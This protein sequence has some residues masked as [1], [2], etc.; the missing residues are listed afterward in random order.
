M[1]DD[2]QH[3]D[4][5]HDDD[6]QDDDQRDDD[7]QDDELELIRNDPAGARKTITALRGEAMEARRRLRK[8]EGELERLKREG[9]SEQ[10][11]AVAE[12]EA[13][14]REQALAEAGTKL[15][16]AQVR[17]AAAGKLRDPDD[18]VRYLDLRELVELD[19][20][21]RELGK[22]IDKLVE[23]KPYLGADNGERPR[24]G[25]RSQGARTAP[26]GTKQTDAD[27]SAWLRKAARRR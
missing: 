15:L 22:R 24:V 12:A 19:E 5:Q 13:R 7:Q 11:R 18:A 25:A 9:L 27:G 6:Q 17:A 20:D 16:E 2:D 1:A 4:Q 8:L 3:D 26:G 21:E 14:G 23:A 10:E